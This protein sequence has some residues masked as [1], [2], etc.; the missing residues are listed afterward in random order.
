MWRCVKIVMKFAV[1]D[2]ET[3]ECDVL[4]YHLLSLIFSTS[5][6]NMALKLTI[7]QYPPGSLL[8]STIST[9]CYNKGTSSPS[10]ALI[11]VSHLK[12]STRST[13]IDSF[14]GLLRATGWSQLG[15][16]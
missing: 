8:A 11:T 16:S 12:R 4:L 9:N 5:T 2:E 10:Q 7:T 14:D 15:S 1:D 6:T 13:S 3:V